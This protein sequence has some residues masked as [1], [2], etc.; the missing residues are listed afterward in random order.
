MD[1]NISW[2]DLHIHSTAS[3]GTFTPLEIVAQAESIGLSAISVTDHDTVT[4]SIEALNAKT[5]VSVIS[6]I[7]ISSN[8]PLFSDFEISASFHILGYLFDPYEEKLNEMLRELQES[9]ENRNPLI[10]QKL[11]KLGF[12]ITI[13]E[14]KELSGGQVGRPHMAKLML[15]KGYVKSI[16]EAFDLYLAQ[17]AKAHV[18][19]FRPNSDEVIKLIKGAG[20][21]PV[22]AH[23]GLLNISD[24][25]FNTL[26]KELKRQ[27]IMGIEAY[28]SKHDKNRT[29]FFIDCAQNNDLIVTGGSDFH[30]ANKENVKLGEGAGDLFVPHKLYQNLLTQKT[31]KAGK[32]G[33]YI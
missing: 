29:S 13:D 27:G 11:N 21:I 6:G 31:V 16:S 12:E 33:K 1:N 22:L 5:K 17:G 32:N 23:P 15:K 30:G 3:D 7:E 26:I 24:E 14:I 10:V 4:G 25:N 8:P 19:K 2:I 9:R 18:G 20:G 28:Y